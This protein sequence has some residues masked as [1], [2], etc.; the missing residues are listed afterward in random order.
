MNRKQ[1]VLDQLLERCALQ[2]N[3]AGITQKGMAL[4]HKMRA[5]RKMALQATYL[6]YSIQR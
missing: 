5:E 3:E 1:K 4:V 6:R 2:I